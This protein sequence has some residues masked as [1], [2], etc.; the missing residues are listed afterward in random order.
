MAL[1][2]LWFCLSLVLNRLGNGAALSYDSDSELLTPR[3]VLFL[4]GVLP[5]GIH[6]ICS[7][8]LIVNALQNYYYLREAR[9]VNKGTSDVI[10]PAYYY[11]N[12]DFQGLINTFTY[13]CIKISQ[14]D[15]GQK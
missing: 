9:L 8:P 6:I 13:S 15:S 7:L 12:L 14:G 10:L 4:C 11:T 1:E 5:T 3:P 2:S